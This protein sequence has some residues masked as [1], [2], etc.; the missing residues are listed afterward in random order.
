MLTKVGQEQ[1]SAF[2]DLSKDEKMKFFA[3]NRMAMGEELSVAIQEVTTR[4]TKRTE[5]I[6]FK[7]TGEFMDEHDVREKYAK[8]PDQAEAILQNSR[9]M[10]DPMRGVT[11]YEDMKYTSK[12]GQTDMLEKTT[13]QSISHDRFVKGKPV[14]KDKSGTEVAIKDE[15]V[16]KAIEFSE[17]Q[18]ITLEELTADIAD[19]NAVL[20]VELQN[21]KTNEVKEFMVQASITQAEACGCKVK[22]YIAIVELALDS[23]T[24]DFKELK[25]QHRE[26]KANCKD[27]V[28]R[29]KAQIKIGMSLKSEL[30]GD[31]VPKGKK[32]KTAEVAKAGDVQ[33]GVEL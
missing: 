32:R 7:G 28:R 1:A 19:V 8:K 4:V 17:S 16:E 18:K 33:A 24:G 15:V 6:E 5:E 14:K 31:K 2:R 22:E 13:S 21:I 30:L 27:Q 26:L 11:L 12:V 3:K 23:N 25:S 9:S 20:D 10:F 29:L